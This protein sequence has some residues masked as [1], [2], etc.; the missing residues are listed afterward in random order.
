MLKIKKEHIGKRIVRGNETIEL[1]ADL[2]QR[3]LLSIKNLISVD[4]VEEHIEEIEAPKKESLLSKAKRQVKDYIKS[5]DKNNKE[6][7]Q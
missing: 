3:Q 7:K 6:S 5:D 1:T 2:S 4:Y